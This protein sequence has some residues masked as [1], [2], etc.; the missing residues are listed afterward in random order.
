MDI[1][2]SG[3]VEQMFHLLVSSQAFV[4]KLPMSLQILSTKKYALICINH[5]EF[6]V[7]L[8]TWFVM[9]KKSEWTVK[10]LK[11]YAIPIRYVSSPTTQI[12][13][14]SEYVLYFFLFCCYS[15]LIWLLQIS[16]KIFHRSFAGILTWFSTSFCTTDK[17]LPKR[18]YGFLRIYIDW[19][20]FDS[21]GTSFKCSSRHRLDTN[22]SSEHCSCRVT[23]RNYC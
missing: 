22:L 16:E 12:Q 17:Y 15:F 4:D 1:P 2:I 13:I 8:Q 6:E 14:Y 5:R 19:F 9:L 3:T 10:D 18:E 20:P 7:A 11:E 21:C 23:E